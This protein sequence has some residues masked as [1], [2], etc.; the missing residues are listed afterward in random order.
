MNADRIL[1][2]FDTINIAKIEITSLGG[3]QKYRHH[4]FR[5]PPPPAQ[6]LFKQ[7]PLNFLC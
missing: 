4:N 6:Q 3:V 7:T 2:N 1:K 5:D